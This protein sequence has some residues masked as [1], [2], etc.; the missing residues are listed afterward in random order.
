MPGATTASAHPH[1]QV[2]SHV[3]ADGAPAADRVAL[4]PLLLPDDLVLGPGGRPLPGRF[5]GAPQGA[6]VHTFGS[7]FQVGSG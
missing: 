7:L 3:L 5:L 1:P 2:C 4:A 6:P